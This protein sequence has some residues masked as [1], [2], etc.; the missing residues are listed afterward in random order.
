M[1]ASSNLTLFGKTVRRLREELGY[2]QEEL[3]ER[4]GL[5]RNY[6][7]GVER[8]ER[9]IALDNIVKLAKALSVRSRDLFQSLP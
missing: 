8:G 2:S 4:A 5:H 6:V 9:N 7:G 1:P 3:A